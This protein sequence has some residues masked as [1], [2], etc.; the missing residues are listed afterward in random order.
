MLKTGKSLWKKLVEKNWWNHVMCILYRNNLSGF[1]IKILKIDDNF[2]FYF[3]NS[4][5]NNVSKMMDLVQ[6]FCS[7]KSCV[8]Q[9]IFLMQYVW[10]LHMTYVSAHNDFD[11]KLTEY[12][13]SIS[14]FNKGPFL[15][16]VRVVWGFFEPPTHLRKDNLTT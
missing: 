10:L 13:L 4:I 12:F 2:R 3:L 7:T 11:K 6:N 8:V 15:Y 1:V 9:G 14:N 16:Y 5:T